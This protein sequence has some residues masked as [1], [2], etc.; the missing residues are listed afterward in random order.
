MRAG[1]MFE[2][3]VSQAEVARELG[4]SRETA[5]EW[6]SAFRSGGLAALSGAGRAGRLPK[7]SDAQLVEVEQALSNGPRANGFPTELW[8]LARVATVIEQLT[9]VAYSTTRRGGSCANAW[10]GLASDRREKPSRATMRR[11]PPGHV[12]V[13]RL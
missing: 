13:G 9:G 3:G 6:S 2:R 11:S 4:V 1:A 7:L 5:S 8:T 10:D 12:I